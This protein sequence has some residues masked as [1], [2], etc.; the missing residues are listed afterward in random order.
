MKKVV[1]LLSV[2]VLLQSCLE[3]DQSELLLGNKIPLRNAAVKV[4]TLLYGIEGFNSG[5]TLALLSE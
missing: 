4:D 5:V 2:L 3:D 1:I